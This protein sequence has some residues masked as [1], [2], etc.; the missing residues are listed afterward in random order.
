MDKMCITF[1]SWY[2]KNR[3]KHMVLSVKE[4]YTV[5]EEETAWVFG[6]KSAIDIKV[7]AYLLRLADING[8]IT[9]TA[10]LRKRLAV[11]LDIS[12]QQITNS[13]SSLKNEKLIEG[14]RQK[15]SILL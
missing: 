7:F 11:L 12:M 9:F 1:D 6:L 10:T 13:L 15:Y 14:K 4:L 8:N 5:Y 3:I 2:R